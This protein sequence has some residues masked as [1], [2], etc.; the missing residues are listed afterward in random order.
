MKDTVNSMF[1]MTVKDAIK[2][3]GKTLSVGGPCVNKQ[4]FGG[5][6]VDESGNSFD[7]YVPLGKDLGIDE[8]TILLAIKGDYSAEEFVGKTLKNAS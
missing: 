2:V 3:S 7:A 5:R 6:L 8:S 4:K 1:Q